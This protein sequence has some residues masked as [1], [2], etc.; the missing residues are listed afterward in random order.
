[1]SLCFETERITG[2]GFMNWQTTAYLQD[3]DGELM[4]L[5]VEDGADPS[6]SLEAAEQTAR[7]I[8]GEAL[9]P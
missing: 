9:K 5:A 7:C 6:L 3:A 8:L 1:M 2:N 4:L